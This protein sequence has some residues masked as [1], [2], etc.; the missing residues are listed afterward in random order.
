MRL[1][2]DAVKLGGFAGWCV[3]G[4]WLG[5]YRVKWL[6]G[7]VSRFVG[8]RKRWFRDILLGVGC[9][10]SAAGLK[11]TVAARALVSGV[12]L[13][14]VPRVWFARRPILCWTLARGALWPQARWS[15]SRF[16]GP[17]GSPRVWR[18]AGSW[19]RQLVSWP[20]VCGECARGTGASGGWWCLVVACWVFGVVRVS[21]VVLVVMWLGPPWWGP[22]PFVVRSC[23]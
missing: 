17:L 4:V 3:V 6:L 1:V 22:Q 8:D 23:F 20:R 14:G 9:R 19:R 16:V 10:V 21:V 13:P 2:G 7:F 18:G 15:L 5:W 11:V 12:V